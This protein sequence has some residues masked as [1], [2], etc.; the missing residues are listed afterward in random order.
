MCWDKPFKTYEEQIKHL[1]T[2]YHLIISNPQNAYNILSNIPYYD[3][4]NGYKEC[5]MVDDRFIDTSIEDIYQLLVFDRSIQNI[6]FKY[7][8]YVENRFKN[9]LA[10]HMAQNFGVDV[11]SYISINAFKDEHSYKKIRTAIDSIL[12]SE[13][14]EN[15]TKHYKNTKNHIP[16]WI[17]FKNITFNDSIDIFNKL[18]TETKN[19]ICSDLVEVSKIT[20][21]SIYCF[22]ALM[23]IRK[24]RNKI[25][26]NLK[27]IQYRANIEIR[28]KDLSKLYGGSLIETV[29]YPEKRGR[30]D[31]Y[32]F[33]MSLTSIL[34]DRNLILDF[35]SDFI[36]QINLSNNKFQNSNL[37]EKYCEVTKIPLNIESRMSRYI[38]NNTK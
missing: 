7:S 28:L 9:I 4:I 12:N 11:D 23:L 38:K 8:I 30:N 22:K 13:H 14:L 36:I 33:I 20:N 6:L 27:F 5:F 37:W 17:L 2:K 3:L 35:F 1:Q 24:F 10:Y 18:N 31:I 32:A 15:P 29:D 21:P 34:K 19:K 26:H 16:P 25:A